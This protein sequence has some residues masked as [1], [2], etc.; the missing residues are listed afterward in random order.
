MNIYLDS[1]RKEDAEA[2]VRLGFV[3]GMTTNPT[4]MR[5]VTDDPLQHAKELLAATDFAEFY[6]QPS[7]RYASALEEAETAWSLDPDRVVLKIPATPGGATLAR[8]LRD[9]NVP[10]ALTAAQSPSTMAVAEALGCLAVIPYLDR[11]WRDQRTPSDLV[12]RLA[13]TRRKNTRIV[14]ASVKHAG[15]FA[16]AFAEGA[17]AVT[18]P[19]A[20]LEELLAHPAALE[21]ERA[22]AAEYGEA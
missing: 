17:D 4:L 18:A 9:R 16:A 13:A 20:V 3:G 8:H 14:A 5:K 7:G 10:V 21:A 15:Q 22:F 6:Y 19:L 12:A 11:A 2:A 1:A